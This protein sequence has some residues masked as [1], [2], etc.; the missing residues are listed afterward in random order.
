MPYYELTSN[1]IENYVSIIGNEFG[2]IISNIINQIFSPNNK[3]LLFTSEV[4]ALNTNKV[5]L[6]YDQKNNSNC[7]FLWYAKILS[8]TNVYELPIFTVSFLN[9][10]NGNYISI[11]PMKDVINAFDNKTG[12]PKIIGNIFEIPSN[13]FNNL[14]V[15]IQNNLPQTKLQ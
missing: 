8:K 7:H 6:Y 4:I 12:R 1:E 2:T 10:K 5:L 14:F 11:V 9:K 13:V 15:Q 3:L